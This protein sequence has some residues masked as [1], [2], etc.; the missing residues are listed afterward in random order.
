LKPAGAI[1]RKADAIINGDGA[2]IAD[3]VPV[4]DVAPEFVA[5]RRCA[6]SHV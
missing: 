6:A 2:L 5:R 4:G 3:N 1:L